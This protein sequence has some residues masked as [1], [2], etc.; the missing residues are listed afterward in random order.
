MAGKKPKGKGPQFT[1]FM[2]P[3]IAALKELGGSGRPAEVKEVIVGTL[4]LTEQEQSQLMAS[5]TSRFDNQVDWARYYL[6][7]AG[8]LDSSR[9]GVW[10]LT[11]KGMKAE[12]SD[13]D[14][15][16]IF[17][18][19]HER[20]TTGKSG[21]PREEQAEKGEPSPAN[22][23]AAPPP[24][25]DYRA[26]LLQLLK[27]MPPPGFERLCRRLL[28]EAGFQQVTVTGRS[29]DG[30]IDGNGVL[31]INPLVSFRVLFQ[32]KRYSGSINTS[33]VRDFR[34]AM[35][36]RTDKGILLTT[37]TFTPEARKEA[38][39]EGAPPIELVDGEK[40]MDMLQ[41]H[42]LGLTPKTVY[43]VNEEFFREFMSPAASFP[44]G[45]PL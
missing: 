1:R 24:E 23:E 3:V 2:A 41:E 36:G 6:A 11:D 32:C 31:E 29:G 5:G 17:R 25:S 26:Q 10:S 37:G 14:S 33:Q 7:R 16:R 21:G 18:E 42:G 40:L 9:R 8:Y 28:L 22:E 34:G 12:L 43:V 30:G 45:G 20:S 39:R 19:V 38:L 27:T 44:P 4:G 35:T 13:E 15:R